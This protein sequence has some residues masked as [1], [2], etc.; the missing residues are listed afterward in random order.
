MLNGRLIAT[1]RM[2]VTS[3]VIIFEGEPCVDMDK[4]LV[5]V[6]EKRPT[7]KNKPYRIRFRQ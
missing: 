5:N 7:L 2:N 3:E 4:V 1:E 6:L